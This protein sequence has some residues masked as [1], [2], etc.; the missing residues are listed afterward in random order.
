MKRL[1][2]TFNELFFGLVFFFILGISGMGLFLSFHV[3]CMRPPPPLHIML[4]GGKVARLGQ[5]FGFR[6]QALVLGWGVFL[7]VAFCGLSAGF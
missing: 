1:L 2:I 7:I 5:C 4:G 6:L 3:R